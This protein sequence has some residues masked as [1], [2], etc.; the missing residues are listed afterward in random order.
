MTVLVYYDAAT[1][2]PLFTIEAISDIA[3]PAGDH[4]EI[5]S[6]PA[7]LHLWQ[8]VDGELVR[9][10]DADALAL[11]QAREGAVLSKSAFLIACKAAGLLSAEDA[12]LAS[13][14]DL[15]TAYAAAIAEWPQEMVDDLEIMWPSITE[16]ERMHPLILAV[17]EAMSIPAAMLDALFGIGE[18]PA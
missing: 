16:I 9:R 10:E 13:K 11:A 12:K 17:A 5:E 15:P 7:D 18:E 14:G 6:A 8:V 4:I 1:G 2:A 3:L